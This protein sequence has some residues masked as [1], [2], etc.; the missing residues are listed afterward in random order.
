MDSGQD[1][2]AGT[3]GLLRRVCLGGAHLTHADDVGVV[4][5]GHIQQHVLIDVLLGVFALSGDRVDDAV[6][7]PAIFLPYQ[8]QLT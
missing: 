2:V 3:G 1:T 6:A 4:P 8:I 5:Q 7:H